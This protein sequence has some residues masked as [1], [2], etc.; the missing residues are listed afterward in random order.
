MTKEIHYDLEF[1]DTEVIAVSPEGRTFLG[2][3]DISSRRMR[4]LYLAAVDAG[5]HVRF[6]TTR[7]RDEI[8]AIA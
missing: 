4:P 3:A 1:T 7:L 5:L 2:T 6:E 8:A